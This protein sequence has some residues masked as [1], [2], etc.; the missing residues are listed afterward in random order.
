M[1]LYARLAQTP[2]DL[3]V[4]FLPKE[5]VDVLRHVRTDVGQGHELL[6]ARLHERIE[7]TKVLGQQARSG[8]A[9]LRNA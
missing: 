2:N 3:P 6:T 4:V 1:R 9:D 8:L 5:C 7:V